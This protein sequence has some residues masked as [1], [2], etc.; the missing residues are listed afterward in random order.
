[1]V[2]YYPALKEHRLMLQECDSVLKR[3]AP[4]SLSK[5]IQN[6]FIFCLNEYMKWKI[7]SDMEKV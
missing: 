1:M 4:I 6:E 7:I 2:K 5:G 3:I